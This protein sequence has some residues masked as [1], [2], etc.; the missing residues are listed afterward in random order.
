MTP[1]H[2]WNSRKGYS[3]PDEPAQ[4]VQKGDAMS[5]IRTKG[6]EGEPEYFYYWVPNEELRRIK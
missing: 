2:L 4:L 5:Q 1:T 6:E 3:L